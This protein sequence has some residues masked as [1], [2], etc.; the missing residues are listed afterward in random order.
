MSTTVNRV[1]QDVWDKLLEAYREDPG[2]HSNAARHAV[3]QRRTAR[4]AWEL[5]YPDRPWGLKPIKDLL[6]SEAELA[7][8]RLQLEADKE[9]LEEDQIALELERDREASRQHAIRSKEQEG[10]LIAAARAGSIMGLSAAIEIAPSLQRAMQ[11]LGTA[12]AAIAEDQGSLTAKDVANLSFVMRRYS[13]TLRELS[14]AGQIAMEME[15]LYLG[16]PSQIIGVTTDLDTMPLQELVKM[17]GY[18]DDVLKRAYDRGLI[19][20]DGGLGKDPNEKKA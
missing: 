16:E 20:L 10:R 6:A 17:A 13:S 3:V 8:S 4:R 19:V 2:N 7:R 11:K 12:L 15:R 9:E 5:G 1:T 18:Q 14:Q